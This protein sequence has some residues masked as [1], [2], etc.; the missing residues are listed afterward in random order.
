MPKNMRHSIN[1]KMFIEMIRLQTIGGKWVNT[2]D[3]ISN[4]HF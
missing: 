2:G 3:I 1:K 4:I